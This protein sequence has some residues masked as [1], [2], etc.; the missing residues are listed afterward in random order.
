[1][2]LKFENRADLAA[3]TEDHFPGQLGNFCGAK[4]CLDRE[5]N[6]QAVAIRMPRAL[7]EKQEIV[8]VVCRKYLG[9]FA[10][11]LAQIDCNL[12]LEHSNLSANGNFARVNCIALHQKLASRKLAPFYAK[13][14]QLSD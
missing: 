1:M 3:G 9:L 7:G 6:N 13:R 12:I 2:V 4:A 5:Q 11:H 8:D 10:C 14:S